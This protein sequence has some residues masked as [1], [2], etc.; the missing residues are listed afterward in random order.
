MSV[1]RS[2]DQWTLV[3]LDCGVEPSFAKQW[4]PVFAETID[5]NTFSK[6]DEE[7]DDFLGQILH[8]SG[9]LKKLEESLYYKTPGLLMKTWPSRFKS[10]A[11]ELP[12]LKNPEALANKVYSGRL[13]NILQGDGWRYRGSGLIQ[14]TGGDN[15]KALQK[16]T[17]IRVFDDPEVLRRPTVE[18]LQ[19]VIAWW[20]GNVPDVIMGNVRKVTRAVNGGE[21][22]LAHRI[23][24]TALADRAIE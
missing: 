17:G 5:D 16:I 14:V 9:M 12:Y 23:Q 22:G 3:L 2:E 7:I 6:G 19:V 11:D 18:A 20:E 4:A 10:L 15:L 13:G 1:I 8:E 21:I 24:V